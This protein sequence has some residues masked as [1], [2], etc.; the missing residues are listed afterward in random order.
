MRLERAIHVRAGD[1]R[2]RQPHR[3][4]RGVPQLRRVGSLGCPRD[5][6]GTGSGRQADGALR[7]HGK[8]AGATL[9]KAKEIQAPFAGQSRRHRD[10]VV[11]ECKS[12]AI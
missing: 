1:V 7:P 3:V 9:L 11:R 5:K 4:V 2:P 10:F 12:E 6:S 8:R